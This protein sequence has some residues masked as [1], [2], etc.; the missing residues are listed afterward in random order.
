LRAICDPS[1]PQRALAERRE[2]F[3]RIAPLHR[4]ALVMADGVPAAGG[5]CV[6]DG[7]VAGLFSMRTQ[8]AYRRQG[9]A[10]AVALRLLGWARERRSDL[11]YL[12]VE[13]DNAVA[14]GLYRQLGFERLY[15]YH[16]REKA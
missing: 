6:A 1:L 8:P 14:L 11:L 4:F 5:L 7:N 16:Y 15:G 13:D 10:H 2:L 12:Q 3:A 9:L